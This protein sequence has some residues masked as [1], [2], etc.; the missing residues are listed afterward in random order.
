MKKKVMV[1]REDP[2]VPGE[3]AWEEEHQETAD[4]STKVW[5]GKVCPSNL[6]E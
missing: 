1:G 6:L 4:D 3:I 5:I 2:D